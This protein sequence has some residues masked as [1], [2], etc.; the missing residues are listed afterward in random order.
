MRRAV[1][2]M[3]YTFLTGVVAL[4]LLLS[5]IVLA[6]STYELTRSTVSSGGAVSAGG[7]YTLGGTAGQMDAGQLASG[8]YTLGGGF[9]G[10][11]TVTAQNGHIH[12]LPLVVR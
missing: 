1:I 8:S 11:G 6:A 9:W 2:A 12:Y 4:A 10:G 3:K 5:G 7:G